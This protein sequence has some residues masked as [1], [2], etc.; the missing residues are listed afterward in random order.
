MIY[1]TNAVTLNMEGKGREGK[2]REGKGREAKRREEKR[3]EEKRREEKRREEKRREEKRREEKRREDVTSWQDG[4]HCLS[5]HVTAI[6]VSH[7]LPYLQPTLPTPTKGNNPPVSLC[8]S[9][10]TSFLSL[11]ISCSSSPTFLL[12]LSLTL[13]SSLCKADECVWGR[14]PSSGCWHFANWDSNSLILSSYC[15]CGKNMLRVKPRPGA[16]SLALSSAPLLFKI[17]FAP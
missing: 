9:T 1:L 15:S 11:S 16:I 3:R 7:K 6:L 2:G 13:S 17:N 5:K 14:S 12:C 8:F 4:G 10:I